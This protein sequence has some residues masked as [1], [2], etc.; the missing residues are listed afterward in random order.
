MKITNCHKLQKGVIYRITS[1]KLQHTNEPSELTFSSPI[2]LRNLFE[3]THLEPL[4]G[5]TGIQKCH[6]REIGEWT[7]QELGFHWFVDGYF[8]AEKVDG[9]ETKEDGSRIKAKCFQASLEQG[10][11]Y[12]VTSVR[13]F[14]LP[15]NSYDC[16]MQL[17]YACDKTQRYFFTYFKRDN[18][19][20]TKCIV[21]YNAVTLMECTE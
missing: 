20:S 8:Y 3:F 2:L 14:T 5:D 12:V 21:P 4:S 9:I 13:Q 17:D 1:F 7:K 6:F 10:S 16:V 15:N 18:K 11:L 19:T